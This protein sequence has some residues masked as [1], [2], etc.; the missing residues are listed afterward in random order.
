MDRGIV[1]QVCDESSRIQRFEGVHEAVAPT[2][3]GLDLE[4]GPA[5]PLELFPDRRPADTEPVGQLLARDAP[6][7]TQQMEQSMGGVRLAHR[8]D[9]SRGCQGIQ[10]V[11]STTGRR[12]R[13]R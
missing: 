7:V 11:P 6:L 2:R 12:E 1:G 9:R 10:G 3:D 4:A 13:G 8:F 5:Q